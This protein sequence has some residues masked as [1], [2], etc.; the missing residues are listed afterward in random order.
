[1]SQPVRANASLNTGAFGCILD[2][3]QNPQAIRVAY[4]A[5]AEYGDSGF[6]AAPEVSRSFHIAAS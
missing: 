2:N 6:R 1:M 3:L 4:P 5:R